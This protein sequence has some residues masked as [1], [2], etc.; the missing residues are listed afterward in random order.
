MILKGDMEYVTI[1]PHDLEIVKRNAEAMCMGGKSNVRKGKD[2]MDNLSK[3]QMVGQIAEYCACLVLTGNPDAYFAKRE[4]MNANPRSSDGGS[5]LHG[6]ERLD[7]KGRGYESE[8]FFYHR[9]MLVQP[10]EMRKGW[11]Y[12]HCLVPRY[13][14]D[15]CYV[16]G[17]AMDD[18][19]P[20][21]PY[22]GDIEWMRGIY[23]IPLT[24]L[25]PITE[26]K[27]KLANE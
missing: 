10:N 12:V 8:N 19:F 24:L 20:D 11:R 23:Y 5:D 3:D 6:I 4:I 1:N 25:R 17:W 13:K 27:S 2:R 18:D 14:M 16:A 9:G 22:D 26:L 21:K 7:I 15:G